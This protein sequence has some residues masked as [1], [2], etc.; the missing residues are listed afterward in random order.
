MKNF[1]L[2]NKQN[3]KPSAK[4]DSVVPECENSFD[5]CAKEWNE[6]KSSGGDLNLRTLCSH[7]LVKQD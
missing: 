5:C 2:P 3:Q 6:K 1:H 7:S 4:I